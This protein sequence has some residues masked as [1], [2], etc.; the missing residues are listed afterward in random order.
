MRSH[1]TL[2]LRVFALVLVA[3]CLAACTDLDS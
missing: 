2:G 1:A 3:A